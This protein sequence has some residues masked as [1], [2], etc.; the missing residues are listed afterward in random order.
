MKTIIFT[1]ELGAGLGHIMPLLRI[2]QAMRSRLTAAGEAPFRAVFVLH[3]PHHIRP[4]L[5][6]HDHV[7]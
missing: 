3:D 1:A 5:A 4:H 2:A 7:P 6:A